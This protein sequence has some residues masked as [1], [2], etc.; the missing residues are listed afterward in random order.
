MQ[1][2]GVLQLLPWLVLAQG[3]LLATA[4]FSNRRHKSNRYLGAFITLLSLHGLVALAWLGVDAVAIPE[5]VVLFTCL[6]F[7]YGPLIYRYVW[8][9]LFRNV[10]PSVPFILHAIPAVMN[11]AIYAFYYVV[12]GRDLFAQLSHSVFSG[13]APIY[14]LVVEGAKVL[15]G[16][17]YSVLIIQL[18]YRNIGA[19][20]RW[21]AQRERRRWLTALVTVFALNWLIVLFA[22]PILWNDSTSPTTRTVVTSLQLIAFLAFLYLLTFFAVRYPAVLNPRKAREAIRYK[23]N[24]PPGFVEEALRRLDTIIERREYT[25]SEMTLN[26][27]AETIGVHPNVLSY[28]VNEELGS[29]FREYLNGLRLEEFLRLAQQSNNTVSYLGLAHQAGF[30]SKST[31]LRAFRKRY[32]TTPQQY[33]SGTK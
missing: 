5:I 28:I 17:V 16:I 25:D 29:G 7:L 4:T 9:S 10:E 33:L 8:H 1:F 3:I 15:S 22:A 30:A 20:R 19:L 27:L 2:R 31:F 11:I 14:V 24:L 13:S 12:A 32:G 21:A 26:S 23:L 18:L 6:P